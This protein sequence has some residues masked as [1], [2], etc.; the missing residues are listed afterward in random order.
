[1]N[2]LVLGSGGREHALAWKLGQ[3]H[4]VDRVYCAPGNAGIA[5]DAVCVSL[6]LKD[7]AAL[8][9]F[10]KTND[11][12]F[13]MVGPEVPL[14]DGVVDYFEAQGLRIFGPSKAA[15]QL[16]GSKVFSKQF[17]ERHDIPTARFE[18]FSGPEGIEDA[19]K[20]AADNNWA[21]V[22][23]ADGLAAGKGV[24][25]CES[26]DE[27]YAAIDQVAADKAFGDAGNSWIIEETLVGEELSLFVLGDGKTLIPMVPS[28]DYKQAYEGDTGPNT[29]GMGAYAP[30]PFIDD[31]LL[32]HVMASIVT[33]V[34][35]GLLA[36]GIPYKGLL[37]IGLMLTEAGPKVLEFNC[38]FGD[39]E[40][41]PLMMLLE[42]DLLDV[43]E[44]CIDGR[45]ADIDLKWHEGSTATIVLASQGYPGSYEKGKEISGLEAAGALPD[46]KVFHA[47]TT[48]NGDAV[49]T[50]GGRVLNVTA[51]DT[52]LRSALDRAYEA[53]DKIEFEGKQLRRDI[54]YRAFR[55]E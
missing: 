4:A 15:A 35:S 8:V 41:Q 19:R 39:P 50:N 33:P 47:G 38:R 55:H 1:M 12:A 30:V 29:G 17:L 22:V 21:R 24:L 11:I 26:V 49:L 44:L 13:T 36:D 43:F 51:R 46:V 40:T 54:G 32:S 7:H 34:N 9:V 5:D 27:V 48:S 6:D 10:A 23:K 3:S 16:E 45:G 42:S 53:A 28:Q 14:V 18:H 2:I 31:E 20:Y 25:V 37:Y 52:D